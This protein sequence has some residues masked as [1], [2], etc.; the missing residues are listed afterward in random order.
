MEPLYV[1]I[2][3]YLVAAGLF[4]FRLYG[5][6]NAE[7]RRMS[8]IPR[9][10]IADVRDAEKVRIVGTAETAEPPLT[11]PSGRHPC[12]AYEAQV[13]LDANAYG[14]KEFDENCLKLT[15]RDAT[16]MAHLAGHPRLALALEDQSTSGKRW[17]RL[18][19]GVIRAGDEVAVVGT[20]RWEV[21]QDGVGGGYREAPKRL[22]LEHCIVSNEP[23]ARR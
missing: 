12:V 11:S 21:D 3:M 4:A 18:L 5:K 17:T 8:R 14:A 6:Y 10:A 20:A 15:V 22:V 19:E 16:G 1:V 2:P 13:S 23:R 9:R 7:A